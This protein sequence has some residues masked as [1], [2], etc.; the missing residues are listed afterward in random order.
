MQSRE[1]EEKV[2]VTQLMS[3]DESDSQPVFVVSELLWRSD[4][5]TAF[6]EK[7]DRVRR[8]RKTEQASPQTGKGGC[9]NVM[10]SRPHPHGFL[11]F[12]VKV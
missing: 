11:S 9:E 4:E 2:L 6:F 3:S 10:S 8:S 12:A 7:L 1:V 5:V